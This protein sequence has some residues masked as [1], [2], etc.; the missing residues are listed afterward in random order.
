MWKIWN[1]WIKIANAVL[2]LKN[3]KCGPIYPTRASYA[4]P[5]INFVWPYVVFFEKKMG[6]LQK[7]QKSYNIWNKTI[8]MKVVFCCC[9]VV[10]SSSWF[11]GDTREE[12]VVLHIF[13]NRENFTGWFENFPPAK[14]PFPPAK[15]NKS[16]YFLYIQ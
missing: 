6:L 5:I 3:D 11:S 9:L 10:T 14:L 16:F 8:V 15:R 2:S 13:D 4:N 7:K 1:A 12:K